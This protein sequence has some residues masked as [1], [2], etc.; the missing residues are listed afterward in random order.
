MKIHVEYSAQLRL[1][2]GCSAE[3]LDIEEGACPRRLL[4]TIAERHG[5][6]VRELLLGHSGDVSRSILCFVADEQVD[7]QQP[8]ALADGTRVT[9]MSP[10]S[11]G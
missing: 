4:E 1:L 3:T 2:A 10:I 6:A 11:G 5:D 8:P 9:L 7:W